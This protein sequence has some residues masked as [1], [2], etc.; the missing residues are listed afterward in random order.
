MA[1]SEY[2][3]EQKRLDYHWYRSHGVCVICHHRDAFEGHSVCAECLY[4]RQAK[5]R[6]PWTDEQKVKYNDAKKTLYYERK[7][8]GVCT[9]CGK[10]V[11]GGTQMCKEHHLKR[12]KGWQ[13]RN[14]AKRYKE[15]GLCWIC[16]AEP[17]PGKCYCEKHLADKQ[18]EAEQARTHI[19]R[20]KQ[21]RKYGLILPRKGA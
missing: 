6:K 9:A 21:R 10:P 8:A 16:G 1:C 11:W 2:E 17:V 12:K 20:E 5:G 7:A 13:E 3:K 19:D 15:C 18:R 14:P 4:Q